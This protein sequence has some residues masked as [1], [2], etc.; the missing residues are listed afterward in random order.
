MK[1]HSTFRFA[2]FLTT[3]SLFVGVGFAQQETAEE[4]DASDDVPVQASAAGAQPPVEEVVVTGS[5]L[6]RDTFSSIAPLQVITGQVS[7]EIG[8]IDPATILQEST[9]SAGAQIDITFT[10][11]VLDSGPGHSAVDLRG[12]GGE[13]TLVLIN[14][15]RASPAGVEGAPVSPDL[16]LIPSSIVQQYEILL[17]GASSVYGSDAIAGV[18]NV[19][20]RKDFDGFEFE[21]YA[22]SPQEGNGERNTISALWGGN[23]DRGFIGVAA[24]FSRWERVALDDRPWTAGCNLHMEVD[25]GGQVRNDDL[26]YPEIWGMNTTPCKIGFGRRSWDPAVGFG[27]IYYTPGESNTGIPNLSEA[28]LFGIV[29]DLNQDGM[30]DVDFTDYNV[31]GELG[32]GDLFPEYERTSAFAYGEY[33]FAGDMNLT[34]YFEWMYN[35]RQV[36]TYDPG[37]GL[38]EEVPANNPFNLCNPNGVNG[39]DCGLAFDSVMSN[40]VYL[41][42]FIPRYNFPPAVY[43]RFGF[44]SLCPRGAIGPSPLEAHVS[45]LNDRDGVSTEVSQ[46]RFVA[47]I[48]GDFPQL[49]IGSMENWS[50]DLAYIYNDSSGEA[51]RSGVNEQNLLHSLETSRIDPS[52]GMVVCGDGSDGCVPINMFAPSLYAGLVENQ[53]ATQAEWD[54]LNASRLFDTKY[55]QSLLS[56][57]MTGDAFELPGGTALAGIGFELRNDEIDS[58]PNDVARDGLLW[59]YFSDRGAVGD[60]TTRE[61][62][63]EMELPLIAARPA[64]EELTVNFSARYTKDEFYSGSSTYSA[65]F[66]YRPN[67]S[68]LLRGTVGTSYRAPNLRENFLL[69]QSGF[70]SIYD[71]CVVPADAYNP[72]EGGYIPALDERDEHVLE[73][74]RRHGVDPTSLGVLDTSQTSALY[75]LEVYRVGSLGLEEEKSESWTAGFSWEEPYSEAFDVTIGATYYD[76]A[77]SDEVVQLSTQYSVN[78][79]YGDIEGDSV[80]CGNVVRKSLGDGMFGLIDFGNSPFTNRDGLKTRGVDVNVAFDWPT[81]IAGRAVDFGADI[82]LNRK[83]QFQT[84]FID[85]ETGSVDKED[86]VGEFGFP[87]WEGQGIFRVDVDRWRFTWATR[88]IGSVAQD[89]LGVDDW[90]DVFD[91]GSTTCLGPSRGDFQCRD[92][93]YADKYF[94][95]DASVYY[96]G[97]LWS[98]GIGVRNLQNSWPPQ[99]DSDEVGFV[100][101]NT[102]LGRGYDISGRTIFV[103]FEAALQ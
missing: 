68:L 100:Y 33:T 74:C 101:N 63:A 42:E 16:N 43:C 36:N 28:N 21:A 54:Y 49:N 81:Q 69:G 44:A 67:N 70:T 11:L 14:G 17:D 90:S 94:R 5:R 38:F 24:D 58:I 75:S 66:A 98:V 13:R 88:Y 84:I 80:L 29:L 37:A 12:L 102:P 51:F 97:D 79:C 85:L 57:Y 9:S 34:P 46:M 53:F 35:Q 45:I 6:R 83:L 19:I 92:V 26:E 87:E 1:L 99:V 76:I 52:T 72:L 86:Y 55:S 2:V 82:N 61:L 7:R 103:N 93:G 65:K 27:S 59:G 32:H 48:Q 10:G 62:I 39:V 64:V 41:A 73:N 22:Q 3:S 50:F 18:A 60:K 8:Q 78:D 91:G 96:R 4:A 95:H 23:F 47:G 25:Q 71:P 30:P 31:N 15:R 40:P 77:L 56:Y 89:P 20:L